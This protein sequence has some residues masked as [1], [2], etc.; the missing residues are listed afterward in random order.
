MLEVYGACMLRAELCVSLFTQRCRRPVNGPPV[1]W[2]AQKPAK[3]VALHFAN[4]PASHHLLV[5]GTANQPIR[6]LHVR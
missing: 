6:V 3:V 2:L 1:G 5:F 4:H